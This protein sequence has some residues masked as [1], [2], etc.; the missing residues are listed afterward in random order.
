MKVHNFNF[1][2]PIPFMLFTKGLKKTM[3]FNINPD[4]MNFLYVYTGY[5]L[6]QLPDNDNKGFWIFNIMAQ[7]ILPKDVKLVMNYATMTKGNWYYFH[8]E[9]P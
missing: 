5:Q 1:G 6:H 3:K 9:K 7:F 2:L 4:K 8:M